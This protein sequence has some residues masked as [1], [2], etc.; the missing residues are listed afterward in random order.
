MATG[1]EI[2]D[3]LW[4]ALEATPLEVTVG[5]DQPIAVTGGFER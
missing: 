4:Q 2:K 1:A 5:N 3:A